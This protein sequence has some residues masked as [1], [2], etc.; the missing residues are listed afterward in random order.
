MN[1]IYKFSVF[2][3]IVFI[4][5]CN[6]KNKVEQRK[7]FQDDYSAK[8][9]SLI[10]STNPRFFNGVVLITKNGE[11]KYLREHGF[12]D[13]ENKIPI[14]VKDKFRIMSNS[15]QITAVLILKEVEK[16]KINLEDPISEYLP[17]LNQ[18]WADTV[19]VHHLLNMSSGIVDI[20]KPLIFQPGK[21]YR[22]SNPGYGL[23]GRII[24]N[25]NGKT[26]IELAN[27]MFTELGM[28]DTFCYDLDKQNR[29]LIN[30]YWLKEGE[31]DLVEFDSIGFTKETWK[32]FI[33]AGGIVSTV[34]D[35]SI[36]DTKLHKGQI[37]NSEYQ[38]LMISP[39]NRG[40]HAAFDND[41]IGYAYGLRIHDRHPVRH[42][43]HGGRGFG[44]ASIKFYVPEKDADVIVWENVYSRDPNFMAG[45]VVYHFENEIRKIVLNSNLVK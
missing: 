3:A 23:L 9:D 30:G 18:S 36:W 4:V 14:S 19:T 38:Q 16:G 39:S 25:V 29:K 21:G 34:Y 5:G 43:G 28:S 24:E 2:V 6:K 1:F 13:F 45:D 37:L 12:S 11:T 26:Y 10:N 32:D 35:L 42:L 8:I 33:P 27:E 41:T 7:E 20:E 22:Y 44:F 17:E 31:V 40:P 15:K